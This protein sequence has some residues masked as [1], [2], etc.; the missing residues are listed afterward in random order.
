[1]S[2]ETKTNLSKYLSNYIREVGKSKTLQLNEISRDLESKGQT[3]Y[4]FGFG[5]SPFPIPSFIV[6]SLKKHSE[7]KEYLNVQ[8]YPELLKSIAQFHSKVDKIKIDPKSVLIGP[9]SKILIYNIMNTFKQ[10]N[11]LIPVPAWVS[12]GPQAKL[13]GHNIVRIHSSYEN[14]WRVMPDELETACKEN[15]S[16]PLVLI[17]NYP[18]N[19]D[20]LGYTEQELK[21]LADV[22][23]K[24][25]VTVISDEIYGLLH[26]E[27]KHISLARYY[28]EGTII[29]TGLSK[30]CGA[31]GWRLG[32]CILPEELSTNFK[33]SLVGVNSETFSCATTPVELASVEAYSDIERVEKELVYQRK[34]FSAVGS[35]CQK[36]LSKAGVK[37]HPPEGGFYLYIDFSNFKDKFSKMGIKDC[38]SMTAK[39]LQETGVAILPGDAFGARENEFTARL[40][41]V[42]F[43]GRKA[44]EASHKLGLDK[45]I[46]NSF[47]TT[48][49]GKTIEGIQKLTEWLQKS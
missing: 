17:L 2:Q 27:G 8:G 41:Y 5:E 11:I 35:E 1:M 49:C 23:R 28:P 36:L 26:H 21:A 37:V 30:W 20:G 32:V 33:A 10:A 48:N 9:G 47:L 16:L 18:G 40:A 39:V 3:I 43:N 24:Y 22:L 29:T 7:R 42:D 45:P 6:E 12:Y 25:N 14:R 38:T 4:K 15:S 31:G 44:I 34:V 46:D 13:C 19:P